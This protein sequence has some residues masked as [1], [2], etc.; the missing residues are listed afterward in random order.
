MTCLWVCLFFLLQDRVCC[1]RFLLNFFITVI[2]F[3]SSRICLPLFNVFHFFIKLL[4]LFIHCSLILFSC[5]YVFS[6]TS[7]NLC[8]MLIWILF[9]VFISSALAIESSLVSFDD[10]MFADSSWS[11]QSC[12]SVPAS[13]GSNTSFSLYRVLLVCKDLSCVSDWWH[14]LHGCSWVSLEP[15]PVSATWSTVRSSTN[16][17]W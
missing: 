4:I 6:F 16:Y 17:S 10:V 14:Y 12:N 9:W 5:L 7:L 3:F 15:G 8:K 13:E 1:W 2:V 11:A